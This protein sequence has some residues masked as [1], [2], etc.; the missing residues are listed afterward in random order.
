MLRSRIWAFGWQRI[1]TSADMLAKDKNKQRVNV[2]DVVKVGRKK[3]L[4][5]IHKIIQVDDGDNGESYPIFEL[6]P[7]E[8]QTI[9]RGEHQIELQ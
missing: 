7:L 8:P 4:Y 9:F 2:G 5:R 3:D 1:N 6:A